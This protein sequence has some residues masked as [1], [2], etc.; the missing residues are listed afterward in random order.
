MLWL[1]VASKICGSQNGL[2]Y[3]KV[4][5]P[6]TFFPSAEL[7]L[8][9]A[10]LSVTVKQGLKLLQTPRIVKCNWEDNFGEVLGR[11][12][13]EFRG[14]TV[15]KILISNSDSFRDA[16]EV[17]IDAPVILCQNFLCKFISYDLKVE[18]LAHSVFHSE[19]QR[20]AVEVL[21]SR[22]REIV[23]PEKL[24][25]LTGKA[26]RS[27][28]DPNC[29]YCAQH[30]IVMDSEEFRSISFLPLPILDNTKEHFSLFCEVYGKSLSDKDRPS[31]GLFT[32]P[33]AKEHDK[34]NKALLVNSKVRCVITCQE[35]RKPRCVFAAKKLDI[36]A[37]KR[38]DDIADS[39]MYT[40]GSSLFPPASVYSSTIV[41][42]QAL[43]CQDPIEVQ[44]YSSTM[45]AFPQVCYHC[46]APEETLLN[47]SEIVE[48]KKQFAV[49]R[50][51]CFLC[52]SS[53]KR[54]S[55]RQPNLIAK[56]HKS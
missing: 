31:R 45:V 35:C 21:M 43:T 18:D 27:D 5:D 2:L 23:L 24:T 40:C 48:L 22:A 11:V 38:I 1:A 12:G 32:N 16:Q 17:S 44:Y 41:V 4:P 15:S 50:P 30:P 53:G 33:E 54:P 49:V 47:D 14:K 34:N 10:W 25:P 13:E 29:Y 36:L 56:K 52:R 42:H 6:L 8:A 9:F 51:I 55:T 3:G 46:G 28:L 20:N 19:P 7:R 37:K 26:L 39:K